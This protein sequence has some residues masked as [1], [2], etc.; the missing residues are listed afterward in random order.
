[1]YTLMVSNDRGI[2]YSPVATAETPSDFSE[3]MDELDQR[4]TRWYVE[5]P[6][7]KYHFGYRICLVHQ[8][9]VSNTIILPG[10]KTNG[11]AKKI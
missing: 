6:E 4:G 1:M 2:T 7:G 5:D 10:L 3:L 8:I 11:E 9:L